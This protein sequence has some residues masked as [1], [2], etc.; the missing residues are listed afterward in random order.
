M[1]IHLH[2]SELTVF[3][4]ETATDLLARRLDRIDARL[5]GLHTAPRHIARERSGET[6]LVLEPSKDFLQM[7]AQKTSCDTVLTWPIFGNR[8]PFNTLTD[9]LFQHD[10]DGLSERPVMATVDLP[11]EERIPGLVDRFLSN[12]HTKNPILDVELL[13]ENSRRMACEGF[14]WTADSCLVLLACAL[15]SIAEPFNLSMQTA[16]SPRSSLTNRTERAL[17]QGEC[18][19]RLA[20][21]RLGT[22]KPTL[23][24]IQCHFYA[25]GKSRISHQA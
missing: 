9:A 5:E 8:Y 3:S 4:L 20:S 6:Q 17:Q 7:P 21:Y 22:L 23:V 15:G 16:D 14:D 10:A 18:Y 2:E 1:S 19:F 13:I 11:S 25:G 12:V 24:G